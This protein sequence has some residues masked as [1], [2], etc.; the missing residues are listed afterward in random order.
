MLGQN[1]SIGMTSLSGN[2]LC[3]ERL[4]NIMNA[5]MV[6]NHPHRN[7]TTMNNLRVGPTFFKIWGVI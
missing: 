3:A 4:T 2:V 5:S 7:D 6:G 1:A